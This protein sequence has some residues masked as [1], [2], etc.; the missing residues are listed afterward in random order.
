MCVNVYSCGCMIVCGVRTCF[1]LIVCT[2]L[3]ACIFFIMRKHTGF[4]FIPVHMA[5]AVVEC[6][7]VCGCLFNVLLYVSD[8]V[9][10][11]VWAYW[12]VSV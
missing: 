7:R 9:F 2:R 4:F 12:C 10:V 1:S 11:F 5:L 8:L 6:F 3:D